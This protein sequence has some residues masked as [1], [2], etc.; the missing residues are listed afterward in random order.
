MGATHWNLCSM[1]CFSWDSFERAALSVQ[2]LHLKFAIVR[3]HIMLVGGRWMMYCRFHT[4]LELVQV[5]EEIKNAEISCRLWFTAFCWNI[6]P[7]NWR[8]GTKSISKVY[9][10]ELR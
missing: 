3:S 2:A 6:D 10:L 7:L 5:A 1:L 8:A 9:C 4:E